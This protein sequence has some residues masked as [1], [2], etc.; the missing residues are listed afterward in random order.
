MLFNFDLIPSDKIHL[1]KEFIEQ[2]IS[3]EELFQKYLG[4]SSINPK[5]FIRSPFARDTNP[6]LRLSIKDGKIFFK[7]FSSGQGGDIYKLLQALYNVHFTEAIEMIA[8]DFNLIDKA[9][10]TVF[11][12]IKPVFSLQDSKPADIKV[13]LKDYSQEDLNYW[14][15]YYITKEDLIKYDIQP[16]AEVYL[17]GNFHKAWSKKSPIFR[18]LNNGKYKIYEPLAINKARK[19][20]CTTGKDSI[21]NLENLD[22]SKFILI[23]TSSL[24]DA[25]CLNKIGYN[26][27]AGNSETTL[28]SK[29]I[30]DQLS[31]KF[32]V[33][34]NMNS[35]DPGI[36]A[37]ERYTELYN[38]K[39]IFIPFELGLKDPSDCVKAKGLEFT[40]NVFDELVK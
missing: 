18:Y 15:Q 35:D 19:W 9:K 6:S 14:A 31:K 27:I 26:A 23:I 25:I 3:D 24:K 8:R 16:C 22:L 36:K 29:A 40:N 7:C 10:N 1:S 5:A 20:L 39:S 11:K 17:N 38:T 28:F 32:Q 33:L 34:V 4:L 37:A 12:R 30:M 2:N 13:V 21:F